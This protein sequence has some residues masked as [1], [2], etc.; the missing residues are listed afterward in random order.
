M[1]IPV[2][3]TDEH[4]TERWMKIFT[5]IIT[6]DLPDNLKMKTTDQIDI[7]NLSKN[8]YWKSKNLC[9]NILFMIYRKYL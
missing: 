2:I 8:I 6:F 7:E 3:F 9:M 5:H 4:N 1:D